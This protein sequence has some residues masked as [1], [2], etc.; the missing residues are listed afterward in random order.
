[1]K[2]DLTISPFTVQYISKG[3]ANEAQKALL[4]CLQNIRIPFLVGSSINQENGGA[5]TSEILLFDPHWG[6]IGRA[7]LIEIDDTQSLMWIYLPSFPNEDEIE[8]Y[9]QEIRETL[10]P[11]GMT[12]WLFDATGEREKALAYLGKHL[13]E[14]RL[15]L[16]QEIHD[17]L[18]NSLRLVP[19][20]M[21]FI[22]GHPQM[23]Y[24]QGSSAG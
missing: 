12:L 2:N 3:N 4:N 23:L 11:P 20:E 14:H 15:R 9:E 21:P 5:A 17:R 6:G 13:H 22:Q 18:A 16:L 7:E 1:M 24:I 10:P 8:K 19:Y